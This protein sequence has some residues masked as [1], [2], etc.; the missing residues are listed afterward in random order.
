MSHATSGRGNAAYRNVD[1]VGFCSAAASRPR[2]LPS[3]IPSRAA[4]TPL[5]RLI[6]QGC[7]GK[8][9]GRRAGSR[10]ISMARYAEVCVIDTGDRHDRNEMIRFINQLSSSGSQ[11]SFTGNYGVGAKI[12][13]ATKKSGRSHLPVL[14]ERRRLHGAARKNPETGE[15][16][17]RGRESKDGTFSHFFRSIP[18]I[19]PAELAITAQKSS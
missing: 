17:L 19:K 6:E 2:L 10:T 18:A 13:A 12:A 8:L 1:K 14:E 5:R 7:P 15:Y 9:S 16:G 11:Q 4:R 3:S